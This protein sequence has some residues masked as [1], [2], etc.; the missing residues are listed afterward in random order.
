MNSLPAVAPLRNGARRS[1]T[2]WIPRM[3][4]MPLQTVMITSPIE[5]AQAARIAGAIVGLARLIYEPD[6][7]PPIRFQADHKGVAGFQRTPVQEDRWR[8][9][10]AEATI[11]WDFP[12]GALGSG[13]GLTLCPRV[14]WVQTTSSGVGQLVHSLG[15]AESDVIVTTARGVHADALAEFVMLCVLAAAKDLPRLIRDQQAHRWERYCGKDLRGTTLLVIGAGQVG[16]RV[17]DVARAFG[18]RFEAL[19]NTP[20]AERARSIGADAL[21]GPADLHRALAGADHVVLATPHT[22]QTE[23]MIDAA[24]FAAMKPGVVLINIA[25]GQ[26]VDEHCLIANLASGRIRFAGLDVA[27]VEPLPPSSPLWDLPNVLISPHSA[28]TA[29][30]ENGKIVDIFRQNL[31]HYLRGEPQKMINMLDKKRRY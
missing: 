13:G 1:M 9:H 19:V 16:V 8:A 22:P 14:R 29:P 10:L 18:M 28:S 31:E 12:T 21:Y 15:L 20:Q 3:P 23:G 25:R 2:P 6:L 24:A 11:L 26:V 7:L 27:A 5:E 30:S 17:G 4:P